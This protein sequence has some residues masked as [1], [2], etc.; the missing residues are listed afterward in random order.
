MQ[1]MEYNKFILTAFE[2]IKSS[3]EASLNQQI[4]A[5]KP[6]HE[7]KPSNIYI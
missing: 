5:N 7:F 4:I 3:R 6:K 1:I 2:S